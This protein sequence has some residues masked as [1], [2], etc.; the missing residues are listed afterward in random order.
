MYGS[1]HQAL[2]VLS[3]P[4]KA[5]TGPAELLSSLL[6]ETGRIFSAEEHARVAG[7]RVLDR[8]QHGQQTGIQP[9]EQAL[10]T[11][12]RPNAGEE[13]PTDDIA[14]LEKAATLA[15]STFVRD[16]LKATAAL[17][18]DGLVDRDELL[19]RWEAL[20]RTPAEQAAALHRL[21]LILAQQGETEAAVRAAQ[22]GV[23]QLP[24][25]A[26]LWRLLVALKERD[27]A[28]LAEASR[29]CPKDPE[30]WLASLVAGCRTGQDMAA[31]EKEVL[32]ACAA[33]RFSP[34]TIVRAGDLL[35]RHK[36]VKAAREAAR[37]AVQFGDGYVPADTLLVLT[38]FALGD[39]EEAIAAAVRGA[40]HALDPLPF[41]RTLVE[42]KAGRAGGVDSDLLTSLE[43]LRAAFPAEKQWAQ[44]LGQAYFL[45]HDM[46]RA[47]T[48]LDPLV[49]EGE[50]GVSV[51]ALLVSAEAAR[52]QGDHAGAIRILETAYRNHP[53]NK[54]VLNNLIYA[55]AQNP[56]TVSRAEALLP[57]LLN[58][59]ET[60]FEYLDTAAVVFSKAGKNDMAKEYMEKALAALD[61]G[62]YGAAEARLNAA[63]LYLKLG[64]RSLA[65]RHLSVLLK[66]AERGDN[67]DVA[68]RELLKQV[69]ET[70]VSE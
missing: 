34:E 61:E 1:P 7:L 30:I 60:R 68:A 11:R 20:G 5:Y 31:V 43:R 15:Q 64:E 63:Q 69:R 35:F 67:V 59:G 50:E 14:N 6:Y 16:L 10:M 2:F 27:P 28:T 3:P 41:H 54:V 66:D 65:E 17:R 53:D 18:R 36:S 51:E 49:S 12:F 24:Q 13:D 62:K 57:D 70:S 52:V 55:L 42:L 38:A 21:S 56:R 23:E 19:T 33:R 26:A 58:Q 39:R 4:G 8:G 22:R 46:R 29:A 45:K 40:A 9:A 47:R 25:S 37:W 44:M 48:I 32:A